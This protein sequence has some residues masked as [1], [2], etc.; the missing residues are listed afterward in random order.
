MYQAYYFSDQQLIL[1]VYLLYHNYIFV[2]VLFL[3]CSIRLSFCSFYC[4]FSCRLLFDM[5]PSRSK[6]KAYCNKNILLR[7]ITSVIKVNK[8]I[9]QPRLLIQG[10]C[11]LFLNTGSRD[12]WMLSFFNT[13]STTLYAAHLSFHPNM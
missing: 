12:A 3:C 5:G 10:H 6:V 9:Y 2:H 13:F 4:A 11:E 7:T 1:C 8:S